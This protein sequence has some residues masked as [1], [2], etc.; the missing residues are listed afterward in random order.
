MG[1]LGRF[2][3]HY[4]VCD[5]GSGLG[6]A[7]TLF[8][9]DVDEVGWTVRFN[10]TRPVIEQ[11]WGVL[12]GWSSIINLL[13]GIHTPIMFGF[14]FNIWDGWP[15]THYVLTIAYIYICIYGYGSKSHNCHLPFFARLIPDHPKNDKSLPSL[16]YS[17][18]DPYPYMIA[19]HE[20]NTKKTCREIVSSPCDPCA[21]NLIG[22]QHAISR[23]SWPW[24]LAVT[25]MGGDLWIFAQQQ[26]ITDF[27]LGLLTS[28][29][30]Q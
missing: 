6:M 24:T 9:C 19:Y 16:Q 13:T 5:G 30:L 15:Y 3:Q 26:W 8:T 22:L 21:C 20:M 2:N 11:T 28:R 27:F 1:I 12:G 7:Q 10:G 4:L 17:K 25:G 14:P 23:C 18:F 29:S